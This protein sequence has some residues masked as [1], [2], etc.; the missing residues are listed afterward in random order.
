VGVREGAGGRPSGGVD[1]LN[2]SNVTSRGHVGKNG[3]DTSRDD[4]GNL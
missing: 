3:H 1:S 2:P 4:G